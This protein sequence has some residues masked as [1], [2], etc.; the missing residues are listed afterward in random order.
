MSESKRSLQFRP[1]ILFTN[2]Q[3][4]D[5]LLRQYLGRL[6]LADDHSNMSIVSLSSEQSS[7]I[8]DPIDHES[9]N[10]ISNDVY[11]NVCIGGTFDNLHN[12][13]KILLSTAQLKCNRSLTI[14]VTNEQM[15]KTK[16]LPE[17]IEPCEKRIHSLNEYLNDI[18]PYIHYNV[19]EIS[20][21]FGP[22]IVDQTLEAI[23]VSEETIRGGE[24]IN[25]IRLSKGMK[26]LKIDVIKLLQEDHK[27]NKVEENKVSSSSLRMRKLGT[28]LKEPEP[29]PHLPDKPYLIGLTGMIASG[30]SSIAKKLQKLGAGIINVD[31]LAHKTYENSNMPAYKKIVETFGKDILDDNGQINR[32]KLGQIV[33]ND[34]SKL[35]LL[36]S[37]VWPEVRRLLQIEIDAMKTKY[38][39]I[40]L[41]IALLIENYRM[42]QVH[43]VW[44]TILDEKEVTRRLMERNNLSESDALK[45]IEKLMPTNE[46]LPYANVV[47][48]TQW[49]EEFTMEQVKRAWKMLN[50][51]FVK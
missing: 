51:K 33:F 14:G 50:E 21:P 13:H 45:R 35:K 25:E 30:K 38:P 42:D 27:E 4:K 36:N 9:S 39:I 19:C 40:V 10:E 16:T 48:C 20:D 18:D 28:L 6:N 2:E 37:F 5:D 31:M 41:E 43:Q 7:I 47:F 22:A 26:P 3:W 12:G 24:K 34:E 49:E 1:Q 8:S 17:L 11:D 23:I 29:R 46:K 15:L 32:P 44:L